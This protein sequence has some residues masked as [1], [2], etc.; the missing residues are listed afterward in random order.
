MSPL[1]YRDPNVKLAPGKAWHHVRERG[2]AGIRFLRATRRRAQSV[3]AGS[4]GFC[5]NLTVDAWLVRVRSSRHKSVCI[6]SMTRALRGYNS[7]LRKYSKVIAVKGVNP[8]HSIR[9][10]GRDDLQIEYISASDGVAL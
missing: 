6:G 3:S 5:P 7:E 10:H 1:E 2:H 4:F 8:L 9:L